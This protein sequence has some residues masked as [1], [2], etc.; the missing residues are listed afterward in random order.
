[1]P[2]TIVHAGGYAVDGTGTWSWAKGRKREDGSP[3]PDARLGCQDPQVRSHRGLFRLRATRRR[4]GRPDRSRGLGHPLPGRAD[5]IVPACTSP[6]KPVLQAFARMSDAGLPISDVVADRGYTYKNDWAPGLHAMGIDP[7]ADLHATQYGPRGNHEGARIVAGTPHCPAMPTSFRHHP[8]TRTPRRLPRP[9]TVR[10]RH[11]PPRTVG[12]S[13]R[14]RPRPDRQGTLRV[15][16]PRRE[17]PLPPPAHLPRTPPRHADRPRPTRRRRRTDLLPPAHHHRPR[18]GRRQS[19]PAALLGQP[20]LD[21]GVQ[22]P[23]PRRGLVRQH[24]ERQHRGP[25]PRRLPRDGHLQDLLDDRRLRRSHQPPTPPSLGTQHPR[26]RRPD[27]AHRTQR[28]CG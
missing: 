21:Q 11:R 15:P 28:P 26:Q 8:P 24:Q 1:M 7:V 3:D 4:P 27:P 2:T 9:R 13:P 17:T 5:R 6:T 18:R 23:I 16:R 14:R 19:P 22:P 10:R 25:R 20:E 12:T